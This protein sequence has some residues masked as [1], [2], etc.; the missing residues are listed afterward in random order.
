M[1]NTDIDHMEHELQKNI[2]LVMSDIL[3]ID[4]FEKL[5]MLV[6]LEIMLSLCVWKF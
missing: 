1:S 3:C 6:T 4:I 2:M 5:C